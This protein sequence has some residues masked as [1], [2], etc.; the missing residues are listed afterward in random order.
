MSSYNID[1]F[2]LSIISQK[3]CPKNSTGGVN[4]DIDPDTFSAHSVAGVVKKAGEK[5]GDG[6]EYVAGGAKKVYDKVTDNEKEQL[7][8][9]KDRRNNKMTDPQAEWLP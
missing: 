7:Q 5:I 6:I 2:E 4:I 9:P 8:D 1:P 3:N